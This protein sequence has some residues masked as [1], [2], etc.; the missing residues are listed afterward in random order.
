MDARLTVIENTTNKVN[1]NPN[2]DMLPHLPMDSI[3]DINNFETMLESEETQSQLVNIH[4]L[5]FFKYIYY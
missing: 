4:S 3:E 5:I 2:I 1:V